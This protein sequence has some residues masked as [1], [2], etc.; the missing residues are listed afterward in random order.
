MDDKSIDSRDFSMFDDDSMFFAC[1]T[2]DGGQSH[3][4]FTN[5]NDSNKIGYGEGEE[6]VGAVQGTICFS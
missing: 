5:L 4:Q 2:T 6:D 3:S 1:G